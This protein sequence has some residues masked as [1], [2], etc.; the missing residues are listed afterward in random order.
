MLAL[1]DKQQPTPADYEKEK[2]QVKEALLQSKRGQVM[3]LFAQKLHERMQKDGQIKV[4]A[5]EEKRM[6]GSLPTAG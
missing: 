6:F 1:V 5:Q 2:D 3:N 4:N